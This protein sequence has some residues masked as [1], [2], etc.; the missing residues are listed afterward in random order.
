MLWPLRLDVVFEAY[1]IEKSFG[2]L[3]TDSALFAYASVTVDIGISYN[4][5][6]YFA[7]IFNRTEYDPFISSWETASRQ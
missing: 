5:E 7:I 4:K 6:S 1:K 3:F 2:V